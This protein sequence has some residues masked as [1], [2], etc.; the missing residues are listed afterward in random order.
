MIEGGII[1]LDLNGV[2]EG[3]FEKQGLLRSF[4]DLKNDPVIGAAFEHILHMNEDEL[5]LL[6]GCEI[7]G[8]SESQP[9]MTT[10]LR[11][12]PILALRSCYC[13]GDERPGSFVCCNDVDRFRRSNM[14]PAPG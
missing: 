6:T 13:G 4:A 5:M 14:L 8:T 7:V 1:T 11:S 9:K 10:I 3:T 2:P 12:Q